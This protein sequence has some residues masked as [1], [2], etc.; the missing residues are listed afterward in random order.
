MAQGFLVKRGEIEDEEK[1]TG[2][3]IIIPCLCIDRIIEDLII[4]E[5]DLSNLITNN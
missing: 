5:D 2:S 1:E 4:I 3:N